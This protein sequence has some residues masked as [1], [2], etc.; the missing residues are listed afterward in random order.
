MTGDDYVAQGTE[1]L[2][3]R[4]RRLYRTFELGRRMAHKEKKETTKLFEDKEL[5]TECGI[6]FLWI[7]LRVIL[8]IAANTRWQMAP[9]GSPVR[10]S[11]PGYSPP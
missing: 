11:S 8:A 1:T 10:T 4:Y 5:E 3:G 6:L 9:R 2:K 7:A